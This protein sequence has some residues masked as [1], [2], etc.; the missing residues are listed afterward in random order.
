MYSASVHAHVC[1]QDYEVST[2]KILVHKAHQ[3]ALQ[4]REE[5]GVWGEKIK[6]QVKSP[7]NWEVRTHHDHLNNGNLISN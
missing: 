4:Q 1:A 3:S 7:Y 6:W 5:E 2:Y